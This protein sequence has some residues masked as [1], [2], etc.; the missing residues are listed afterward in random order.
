VGVGA[1]LLL[2]KGL[3]AAADPKTTI[4]ILHT[5]DLHSN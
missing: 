2:T 5:S 4:T 1:T 3:F